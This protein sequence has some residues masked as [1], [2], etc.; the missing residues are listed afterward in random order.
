MG[1]AAGLTGGYG[2]TY[3]EGL[4]E[5]QYQSYMSEL[6]DMIPSLYQKAYDKYVSDGAKLEELYNT[7]KKRLDEE[8]GRL[9][10][11]YENEKNT[12]EDVYG[13]EQEKLAQRKA[14]QQAAEKKQEKEEAAKQKAIKEKTEKAEK[15]EKEKKAANEKAAAAAQKTARDNAMMLMKAGRIPDAQTL[16]TA[17]I[18]LR[19][20]EQVAAYYRSLIYKRLYG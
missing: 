3:A 17:G 10:S 8:T 1:K 6:T 15:A 4:G 19:Y 9:K 7:E 14:E 13:R 18:P 11:I 12:Y 20:A 5:Q 16:K 2:S